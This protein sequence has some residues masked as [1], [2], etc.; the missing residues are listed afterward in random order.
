MYLTRIC[1]QLMV[2]AAPSFAA[3]TQGQGCDQPL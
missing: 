3:E 2:L 1:T